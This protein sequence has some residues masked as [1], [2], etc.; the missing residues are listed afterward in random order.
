MGECLEALFLKAFKPIF[1]LK[2][3]R[4]H[5]IFVV[6]IHTQAALPKVTCGSSK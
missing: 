3:A 1:F 6:H 2:P 5:R 4:N